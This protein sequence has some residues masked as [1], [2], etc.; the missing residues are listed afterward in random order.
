MKGYAVL[1]ADAAT[2]EWKE[3]GRTA[4][5]DGTEFDIQD[6]GLQGLERPIFTVATLLPD[7]QAYG[8]RAIAVVGIYSNPVKLKAID[9]PFEEMFASYPSRYFRVHTGKAL[10]VKYPNVSL[11]NL[12]AGSNIL[13]IRCDANATADFNT[14]DYFDPKN[15][16]H[17]G[18]VEMCSLDLSGIDPSEVLSLH[19][20]GALW[21]AKDED[22]ATA[23]MRVLVDGKAVE[24][25]DG[26]LEQQG[27]GVDRDLCKSPLWVQ[28]F[29]GLSP[30]CGWIGF[31]QAI[32]A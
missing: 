7:G 22:L 17:I 4:N 3:I 16:D 18:R 2:E 27:Q 19:I 29:R 10:S 5:A 26:R 21:T 15:A 31:N 24:S 1:M 6:N 30:A 14:N 8:K 32:H 9:L 25:F 20:S 11:S 12:P 28:S 23:R 13:G